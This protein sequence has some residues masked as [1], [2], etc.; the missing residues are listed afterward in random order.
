AKPSML[1]DHEAG[2][3]LEIDYI[4]G[5][6]PRVGAEVG[7]ETPVNYAVTALVKGLSAVS[8]DSTSPNF[9]SMS[10]RFHS[11]TPATRS[12]THSRTTIGRKPSA[13]ASS[14]VWRTHPAIVTPVTST[15]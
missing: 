9:A 5:A 6:I 12:P 8:S 3:R 2:R 7:V 1:L 10:N 11:V 4:N 13:S 15:V 14:T